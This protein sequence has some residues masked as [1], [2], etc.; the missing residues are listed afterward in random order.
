MLLS[1]S[2]NSPRCRHN[3]AASATTSDR[4]ILFPTVFRVDF[5]YFRILDFLPHRHH[6][7]PTY[8]SPVFIPSFEPT[9]QRRFV[10]NLSHSITFPTET[11]RFG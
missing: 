3:T 5:A 10:A 8:A 1:N 9:E 11:S 4:A 6:S 7:T 2:K